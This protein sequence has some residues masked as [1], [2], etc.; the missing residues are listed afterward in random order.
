MN[1][2]LLA[3]KA[4]HTVQQGQ[5]LT[6]GEIKSRARNAACLKNLGREYGDVS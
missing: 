3:C 5:P 6:E 2:I 1:S 4:M